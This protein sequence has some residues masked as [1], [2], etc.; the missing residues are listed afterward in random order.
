M[1]GDFV[2]VVG[3]EPSGQNA[4]L[5]G[6]VG[7]VISLDMTRKKPFGVNIDVKDAPRTINLRRQNLRQP[8][9]GFD[10]K[11]PESQGFSRGWCRFLLAW[12]VPS[13]AW[14]LAPT[15]VVSSVCPCCALSAVSIFPY[16]VCGEKLLTRKGV[17]AN[18]HGCNPPY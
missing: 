11:F 9:P 1:V 14:P 2:E 17:V 4:D 8:P 3:L 13:L 10:T 7:Q 18:T 12:R 5:N 6:L 15:S 16:T